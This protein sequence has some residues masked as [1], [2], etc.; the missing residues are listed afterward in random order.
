M[1]QIFYSKN[2][3]FREEKFTNGELTIYSSKGSEV[4]IDFEKDDADL[5]TL[6][7]MLKSIGFQIDSNSDCM[8]Y[9]T[10]T[11]KKIYNGEI[12]PFMN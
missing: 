10:K 12:N 11:L 7:V 4:I 8:T 1:M 6:A 2:E 5:L 9:D 3:N